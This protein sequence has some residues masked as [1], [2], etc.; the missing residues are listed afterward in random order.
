M[1]AAGGHTCYVAWWYIQG[2][3]D[4]PPSRSLIDWQ[5]VCV[6]AVAGVR[7]LVALTKVDE[8]DPSV[9]A[10]LPNVFCSDCIRNLISLVGTP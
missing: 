9:A 8:Y 4:R 5:R 1:A 6:A 7:V 3:P 10:S 2:V